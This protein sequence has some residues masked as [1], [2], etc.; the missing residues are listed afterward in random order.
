MIATGCSVS[1]EKH[2]TENEHNG[3]S[4][5]L[6][7]QSKEQSTFIDIAKLNTGLNSGREVNN[8][9]FTGT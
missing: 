5:D 3:A 4:G 2:C 8:I 1:A 6:V 9:I 7:L